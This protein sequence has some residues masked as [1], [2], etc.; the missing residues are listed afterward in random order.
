M[1]KGQ[2]KVVR[3]CTKECSLDVE[4]GKVLAEKKIWYQSE[5]RF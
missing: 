1:E 4:V 5:K 2:S 3:S